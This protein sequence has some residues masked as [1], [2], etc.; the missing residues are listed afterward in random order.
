MIADYIIF[1]YHT[2]T[3]R[4][5]RRGETNSFL[6]LNSLGTFVRVAGSNKE[7]LGTPSRE[8]LEVDFL[9]FHHPTPSTFWVFGGFV[10]FLDT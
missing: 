9:Y 5:R 4:L 6:C 7:A 1:R 3:I 8:G 10:T 2:L